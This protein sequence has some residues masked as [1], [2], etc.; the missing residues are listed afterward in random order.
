MV[1]Y[2]IPQPLGPVGLH[3]LP[4]GAHLA[5]GELAALAALAAPHAD[6]APA[7]AKAGRRRPPQP[8]RRPLQRRWGACLNMS[9]HQT[10]SDTCGLQ[11]PNTCCHGT[12]T[13]VWLHNL[14]TVRC[15]G[16]NWEIFGHK[17]PTHAFQLTV[18]VPRHKRKRWDA[19]GYIWG[20]TSW[21]TGGVEGV[22]QDLL[23]ARLRERRQRP[24]RH[25]RARQHPKTLRPQSWLSPHSGLDHRATVFDAVL[26]LKTLLA[27][28]LH[29]PCM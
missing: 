17:Q 10:L 18:T 20:R 19:G 27:G 8:R 12:S 4:R 26:K 13:G 22:V 6:Q 3:V 9:A 5:D 23:R 1:E 15:H 14:H 28:G 16:R 29:P 25:L 7:E 24:Q 2:A 11:C 21:H